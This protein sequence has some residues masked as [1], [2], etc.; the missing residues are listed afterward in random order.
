MRGDWAGGLDRIGT[1]RLAREAV[2]LKSVLYPSHGSKFGD[3]G[4]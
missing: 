3:V 2:E 4:A 1:A